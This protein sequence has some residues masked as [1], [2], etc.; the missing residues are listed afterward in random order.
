MKYYVNVAV[1]GRVR[2]PIEAKDID[3]AASIAENEIANDDFG[4]LSDIEW[5]IDY[6]KSEKGD[7]VYTI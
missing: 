1:S 6:I 3:E 2:I 5:N 7:F 4:V